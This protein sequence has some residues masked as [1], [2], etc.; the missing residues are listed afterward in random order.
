MITTFNS[1]NKIVTFTLAVTLL[2]LWS[3]SKESYFEERERK[4]RTQFDTHEEIFNQIVLM[5]LQDKNVVRIA[6]GFTRLE[7]DYSWPR[8]E[9]GISNARWNLYRSLFLK[10]D[11]QCGIQTYSKSISVKAY[12]INQVDFCVDSDPSGISYMEAPPLKISS[13]FK[14]CLSHPKESCHVLLNNNWYMY[15]N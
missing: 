13:S 12:E 7:N 5:K 14:E 3:C 10:A 1:N 6:P 2:L 15:M 4:L 8:K 9:I 11:I